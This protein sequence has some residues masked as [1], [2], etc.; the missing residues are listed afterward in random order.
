VPECAVLGKVLFVLLSLRTDK[1]CSLVY[2][3]S[4]QAVEFN[5]P[6]AQQG[7][8]YIDEFPTIRCSLELFKFPGIFFQA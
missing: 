6:A 5:V 7:I 3:L 2:L 4:S 8:V 1:A